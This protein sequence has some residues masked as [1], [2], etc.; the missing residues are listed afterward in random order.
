MA[1]HQATS[2]TSVNFLILSLVLCL[3]LTTACTK[4][5]HKVSPAMQDLSSADGI[6][7]KGLTEQLAEKSPQELLATGRSYMEHGNPA[8]ARMHFIAAINND[9]DSPDGYIALAELDLSRGDYETAMINFE[10][11]C[12]D[13]DCPV[14]A[15]LGQA[16]VYRHQGELEQAIKMINS[17][18]LIAPDSTDVILELA[19]IYESTGKQSLATPLYQEIISRAPNS[20]IGNNNLGLNQLARS[21]YQA[22]V[23]SFKRALRTDPKNKRISNNLAMAYAFSGDEASAIHI[24]KSSVGEAGAYNNL[25]YL[26]LTKGELDKA[27]AALKKAMQL[28]PR[29]YVKAQENLERLEQIRRDNAT[30]ETTNATQAALNPE[31]VTAP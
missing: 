3:S 24:F 31:S 22:A 17:A 16:Q 5:V 2:L 6:S 18:M 23:S 7:S 8:L 29:Y 30:M 12:T 11:A 28:N 4:S 21:N 1:T 14:E 27:E 10:A 20:T 19:A 15:L 26:Y 13:D 9:S 25:G